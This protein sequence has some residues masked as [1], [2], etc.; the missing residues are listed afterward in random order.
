M[1]FGFSHA[2]F[3][4]NPL[5]LKNWPDLTVLSVQDGHGIEWQNG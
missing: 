5:G 3:P 4:H 1:S 2:I